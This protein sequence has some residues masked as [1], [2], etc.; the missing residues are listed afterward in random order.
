MTGEDISPD[1][2]TIALDADALL[3]AARQR[4]GLTDIGPT[5]ILEPFE[6]YVRALG[7]EA[8]LT[9]QGA[10]YMSETIIRRLVNRLRMIE[11]IRLHPEIRDEELIILAAIV[12]LPRTGSTMLQRVLT[13]V[14]GINGVRW[15]ELQNFSPF[16]GEIPGQPVERIQFAEKMVEAWLAATPEFATIH[17]LSAT[18]VDEESILLHSMFAGLLEYAAPVPSF[19]AWQNTSDFRETYADLRTTLQFL[20]WQE[21]ARR[22][23]PWLL[24][25]PEHM[26]APEALLEIFPGAK[27]IITHRDPVQVLPSICSMHYTIQKLAI[28]APDRMLIGRSNLERWAAALQRLTTL[29]AKIGDARF[30]DVSYRDLLS[31]P[32]GQ[33]RQVLTALGLTLDA[34]GEA[35][36]NAWLAE[37]ARDQRASHV[38]TAADFGLDDAEMEAA[39]ANYS[40]RFIAA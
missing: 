32:V 18:Q 13:S 19:V 7:T 2:G 25:A 4:T 24:K 23:R 29:R 1:A 35:A 22:G 39:F 8:H 9:A 14:P 21:P 28:E 3:Q 36:V 30:I 10:A 26:I 31:D 40:R 17:P 5:W 37:N 38:Y 15:W 16:P 20:Q 34:E 11:A 27:V 6:I 12:G 33:A